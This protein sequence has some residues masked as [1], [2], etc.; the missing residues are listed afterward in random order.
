MHTE[1]VLYVGTYTNINSKGIY[2]FIWHDETLHLAGCTEAVNPSYLA[3]QGNRLYA[4][5]ETLNGG[6][7]SYRIQPDGTLTLTGEQPVHGDAPCHVLPMGNRL[8]VSNY[9][10]G[11]LA[12]FNPDKDGAITSPPHVIQ[13]HGSSVHLTRQ[14]SAHVHQAQPTADG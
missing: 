7:V 1:T 8:T 14:R 2:R 3:V 13:H 9:T 4:V 11:S 6:A 12:V 10:S 5:R